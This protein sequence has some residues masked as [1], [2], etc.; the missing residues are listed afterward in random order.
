[1]PKPSVL[2]EGKSMAADLAPVAGG[3]LGFLSV[4][5][6]PIGYVGGYLVTNAWGRPLEFRLTSAVQPNRVQ[7]ILYGDTLAAYVCGDLIGKT[8]IEKTATAATCIVT[9]QPLALDLRLRIEVPVALWQSNVSDALG[10]FIQPS[11]YCHRRFPD[12]VYAIRAVVEKLAA[13]DLG[14]PFQRIR[15]AMA[16]ARKLGAVGRLAA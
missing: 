10:L 9:D 16:E 3:N 2:C 15:E 7:Q 12:D 5:Q 14:E 6:E 13:V 11:L 4:L 8:L 1:M